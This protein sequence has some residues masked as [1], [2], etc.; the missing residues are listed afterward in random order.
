MEGIQFVREDH[1]S[2]AEGCYLP[3]AD[4]LGYIQSRLHQISYSHPELNQYIPN[5]LE[6]DLFITWHGDI[7]ILFVS[8]QKRAHLPTR[9][10]ETKHLP[11]I[12]NVGQ[13]HIQNPNEYVDISDSDKV[14]QSFAQLGFA[15]GFAAVGTF[16]A[17]SYTDEAKAAKNAAGE[18]VARLIQ[19]WAQARRHDVE[20]SRIFLSHKGINKPL[21]EKID[22]TLQ[23]LNLKTWFDRDDLAAGDV[24]VR[25]ID[26]AF[27]GCAAAV[28]FISSEYVD[29]GVI[30]KEIDRANHEA[31]M[32]GDSFRIIPL[33]LAQHG[34]NDDRV[35]A[36]IKTLVWKTVDD[37]DIVPTILRGLPAAVQGLIRYAPPKK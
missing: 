13:V 12:L 27:A 35:P 3:R 21:V 1:M 33:V 23:L 31:T 8:P 32:R 7:F 17:G 16:P 18:G 36:S 15:A 37:V 6:V 19:N 25:G 29:A 2:I 24:L 34:G 28:F 22:R 5:L 26:S 9:G 4:L 10:M 11:S 30:S 20:N 14:K